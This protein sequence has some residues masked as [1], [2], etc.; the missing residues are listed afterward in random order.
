MNFHDA[1]TCA[2]WWWARY[3]SWDCPN[4]RWVVV[5]VYAIGEGFRVVCDDIDDYNRWFGPLPPPEDEK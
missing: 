2:G 3:S 4:G 5:E 1:P